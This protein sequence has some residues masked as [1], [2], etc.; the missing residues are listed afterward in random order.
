MVVRFEEQIKKACMQRSHVVERVSEHG[1][2]QKETI[3]LREGES[4]C[5]QKGWPGFEKSHDFV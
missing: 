3:F 2:F 1:P 4:A 5:Q